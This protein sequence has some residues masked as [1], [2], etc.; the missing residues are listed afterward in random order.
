ML[1]SLIENY[2]DKAKGLPFFYAVGD[3]EY[4]SVLNELKQKGVRIIRMSDY[5]SFPDKFPNLDRVIEEFR[6]ADVDCKINKYVLIGL[7]EYLALKGEAEAL[8]VLR[9]LQGTTLGNARVVILLRQVRKQIND[10]AAEDLRLKSQRFYDSGNE[11]KE[12]SVVNV[13]TDTGLGLVKKDGISELLKKFEDGAVGTVYVKS[14]LDLSKSIIKTSTVSNP[15]DAIRLL[16]KGFALPYAYGDD[17]QWNRLLKDLQKCNNSLT[18]VFERYGIDVQEQDVVESAFGLEYKN[19][20]FFI[21]LK[22]NVAQIKNQYMGYVVGITNRFSEFKNNILNAIIEIPHTAL[23]FSGLYKARKKV[24]KN[25]SNEDAAI[26]IRANEIDTA[27]SIYKFT[28]NTLIERQAIVKWVSENRIIPELETIYPSLYYYLKTYTFDCGSL[29]VELTDY[30]KKYKEQKIR[31]IVTPEFLANVTE[32]SNKYAKLDTR[33]N[34]IARIDDKKHC[35]LYWIDAL[36]VEYLSLIQE[37]VKQKGLA[38]DVEIVR[39]DLPTI[40]EINKTFYDEWQGGE[41]CKQSELDDIKH[42][43][44][45]GFDYGKCKAPIH[46][47]NEL[48]VIEKAISTAATQLASHTC[49]KFI[50]ASDHGASRLAVISNIEEKYDTDTKGEHS[51]RCCKYFADYDVD[52][53]ISENG[54]IILT[55]YGRFKKSRAAN[56]EVHGGATLEET[57]IPII[58]L[59]LKSKSEIDIRVLNPDNIVIERKKGITFKLYISDVENQKNVRL[60]VNGK[61]YSANSIDATHYEVVISDIK[62][63]GKYVAD[64]FD[65][66]DLIGNITLNVKGAVGSSNSS[67]DDLF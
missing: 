45:G 24:L 41:K 44:A 59:S 4:L 3:G 28:D 9:K 67:F 63:G 14:A 62:R 60:V 37:L 10:I 46:L 35:Y 50:I 20:L 2:L 48:G 30:F 36:G 5:C 61:S 64:I 39:A 6:L 55:N 12:I 49:K 34:A 29:S 51:G 38:M 18:S 21:A 58:T 16:V 19:W 27:E 40:T 11:C 52:H 7:G 42:K 25:I 31:N 23:N 26:F 54:Y 13:R 66:S 15:Y 8:N 17:E 22:S 32:Y 53:S 33:A 56:V 65:D 57:V 47:A 43:D 1:N